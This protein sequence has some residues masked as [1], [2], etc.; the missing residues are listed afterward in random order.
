[1]QI[2][3]SFRDLKSHHYGQGFEDSLT[4]KPR[5]LEALL[6][7]HA[8]ANFAAWLVGRACELTGLD[9]WLSPRKSTRRLYALVRLGREA[10]VRNWPV[11]KRSELMAVLTHPPADLLDQLGELE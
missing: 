2:E 6:L 9:L 7:I 8:I 4:R 5:R 1:M 3:L 10:L 11:G